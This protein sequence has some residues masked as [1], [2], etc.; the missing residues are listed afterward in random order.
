MFICIIYIHIKALT[1]IFLSDLM[2]MTT[3][4]RRIKLQTKPQ[5]NKE[6]R[7]AAKEK[8]LPLWKLAKAAGISE[9]TMTRKLR[10][11]LTEKEKAR[12]LDL[13]RQY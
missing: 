9:A 10:E 3:E 13:I 12:F 7:T 6:V 1:M 5:E 2:T 4:R 8:G 11:P